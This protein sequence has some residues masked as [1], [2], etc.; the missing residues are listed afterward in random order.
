MAQSMLF[1]D[2]EGWAQL[3]KMGFTFYEIKWGNPIH[4]LAFE[5]AECIVT[6]HNTI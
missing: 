5:A 4:L 1:I 3:L 6:V 2:Q